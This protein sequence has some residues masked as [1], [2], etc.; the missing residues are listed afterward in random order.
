MPTL[1][2]FLTSAQTFELFKTKIWAKIRLGLPNV[3]KSRRSRWKTGH[4]VLAGTEE[5]DTFLHRQLSVSHIWNSRAK[6]CKERFTLSSG[7]FHFSTWLSHTRLTRPYFPIFCQ[8]VAGKKK[9]NHV[10]KVFKLSIRH[11]KYCLTQLLCWVIQQ[12]RFSTTSS[13]FLRRANQTRSDLNGSATLWCSILVGKV[14]WKVVE[15]QSLVSTFAAVNSYFLPFFFFVFFHHLVLARW[16][17]PNESARHH[18]A[19]IFKM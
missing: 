18:L 14:G 7:I 11:P 12:S 9:L 3:C 4:W 13:H 15:G 8:V 19:F 17:T 6:V 5:G 10:Q 2:K 16:A 1:T